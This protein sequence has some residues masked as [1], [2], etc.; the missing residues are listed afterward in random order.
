MPSNLNFHFD[1]E[2]F[3]LNW[4]AAV[5]PTL[6]AL[7]DSG[8]VVND[9][10]VATLAT[11]SGLRTFR[12]SLSQIEYDMLSMSEVVADALLDYLRTG[13]FP[14]GVS[15]CPAWRVGGSFP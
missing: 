8:A 9:V 3:L 1:P 6:T 11:C 15:V 10:R 7:Y 5:D 13:V 12:T 4:Q 2:L 14:V